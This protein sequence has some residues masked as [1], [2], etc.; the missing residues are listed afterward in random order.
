MTVLVV[1]ALTAGMFW[2]PAF[3]PWLQRGAERAVEYVASLWQNGTAE[4]GVYTARRFAGAFLIA[5][6]VVTIVAALILQRVINAVPVGAGAA[7][8]PVRKMQQAKTRGDV[9]AAV[10]RYDLATRKGVAAAMRA[11]FGFA[12]SYGLFF[13]AAGVWQAVRGEP[14][15]LVISALGVSGAIA[16]VL[17]NRAVLAALEPS[18]EADGVRLSPAPGTYA[19]IK[20]ALAG[21]AAAGTLW[22]IVT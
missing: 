1:L 19:P 5:S 17:E 8:N 15:A 16:D 2:L 12:A 10:G 13:T 4:S 11:D 3:A 14:L 6:V 22:F 20:L 7:K 9:V 18:T 21:A